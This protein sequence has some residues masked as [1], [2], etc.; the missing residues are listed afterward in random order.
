MRLAVKFAYDGRNFYGFARQPK[1]RTVEGE[2]ID[3]LIKKN[4]IN[5]AKESVFRAASR[6]DKHVSSF[7]NVIAFNTDAS[8]EEILDNL[9]DEFED[10]VIYASK[11]VSSDFYPRHAKLRHY[12]YPL[13]STDLD[14]EKIMQAA[15]FFIGE[16]DFS[17]FAR[18]EPG[19]NPIRTI[20]N[21]VFEKQGDILK[22][23][24]FAQTFLWHQIRRIMS[25]LVKVGSD[26][27]DL[28]ELKNAL[29]KPDEKKDFGIATAEPLILMDVVYDF[30]FCTIPN[31]IKKL[32]ELKNRIIAN[33]EKL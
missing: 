31:K 17:N 12:S 27:L 8:G 4:I 5:N 24:F 18:I 10:T 3:K 16:H 1:L 14:T 28:N 6:T 33:I 7:G 32:N 19:K 30:E 15:S 2:I 21:I 11:I 25:S 13:N 9:S 26:L 23:D 20:E 29:E 22:I